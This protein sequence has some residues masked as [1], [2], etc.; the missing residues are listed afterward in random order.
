MKKVIIGGISLAALAYAGTTVYFGNEA[1]KQFKNTV[2]VM[3]RVLQEQIAQVPNAPN[4]NL[5]V[6]DYSRG[7]TSASA[8]LR[9]K[10]DLSNLPV[11]VP[12]QNQKMSY[13]LDLIINQGPYIFSQ[14]KPGLAFIQS[15]LTLPES[16]SKQARAQLSD[17]STLP[18]LDLSMFINFDESLK[19][20]TAI[21]SFTLAHK[22]IPGSFV[23][24]GMDMV[25]YL[26][27]D[28]DSVKGQGV[29]KGMELKSPFASASVAKIDMQSDMQATDYGFWVGNASFIV[30]SVK[31]DAQGQT[32]FLLSNW[33]M[34]SRAG[35]DSDMLHAGMDM[36]LDKVSV[37]GKDYGPGNIDF[38]L[39]NVNANAFAEVQNLSQEL[40]QADS[41]PKDKQQELNSKLEK[42][43]IK[44]VS[45]GAEFALKNVRFKMPE[46]D[47]EAAFNLL[48]PK[49]VKVETVVQLSEHIKAA[50]EFSI[51]MV[52]VDTE[53]NKK[54]YR[55]IKYQQQRQRQLALQSQ[56]NQ[57]FDAANDENTVIKTEPVQAPQMLSHQE[58]RDLA[59]QKVENQMNKLIDN[60]IV[61]KKGANYLL[62]FTFDKGHLFVNGKPFTP[63]MFE[64]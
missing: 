62:K 22:Q 58:M 41:L 21:P 10:F 28:L 27:K 51:P 64:Q 49:G 32:M 15:T 57:S 56:M 42:A 63:D 24:K 4:V 43:A 25:Y 59:K 48:V 52:L 2:Q 19:V 31:V 9:V 29:I 14:A 33:K 23:W 5:V 11:P 39:K 6:K 13:D 20:N 3:D 55:K 1:E 34:Q 38:S 53:L 54:A 7:L 16:I 37:M 36:S 40:R 26:S 46:G 61:I 30:P 45:S 47:I 44:M 50:G 17:A 60:Q 18:Q 12:P 35:L 8:K